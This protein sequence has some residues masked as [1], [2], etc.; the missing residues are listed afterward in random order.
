MDNHCV[1]QLGVECESEAV[2]DHVGLQGL[3]VL[4]GVAHSHEHVTRG[5]GPVGAVQHVPLLLHVQKSLMNCL[6]QCE[7]VILKTGEK[8]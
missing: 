5:L 6:V 8:L 7:S 4:E 3:G 1:A 2:L